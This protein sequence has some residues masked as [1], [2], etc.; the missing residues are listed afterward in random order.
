[1]PTQSSQSAAEP[2][3]VFFRRAM[4]A[5]YANVYKAAHQLNEERN[6]AIQER[7]LAEADYARRLK[8]IL[9]NKVRD[10]SPA[11]LFDTHFPSER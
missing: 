10:Y 6:K 11:I 3:R 9:W 4:S 2:S 5:S 7:Q 1:M 8:V